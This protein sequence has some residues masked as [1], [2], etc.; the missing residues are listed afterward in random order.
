MINLSNL[1]QTVQRGKKRLGQGHGS[2]K[3]KTGGRGTK[4]QKSRGSIPFR[5]KEGGV[6][7]VKR[8]PLFR[9]KYKNKPIT[10]KPIVVNLKDL[11]DLQKNT[12]VDRNLLK[13]MN[14]LKDEFLSFYNVKIL[15]DGEIKVPLSIKLPC[16]KNAAKKIE[17]AGGKIIT[18]SEK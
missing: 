10:S 7:F 11:K 5:I 2:G 13:K 4:G 6:A 9:G 14:I 3:G 15:G 18:D 17:K 12:V 1:P 8:L 16:S